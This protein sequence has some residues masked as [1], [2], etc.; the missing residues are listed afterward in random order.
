MLGHW[1]K[2]WATSRALY[3]ETFPNLSRFL[4]DTH[5]QPIG[6]TIFSVVSTGLN[7]VRDLK[8]SSQ[9]LMPSSLM[10]QSL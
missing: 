4:T 6:L 2:P 9:D 10:A 7:T 5:L 8:H 1:V 3:H